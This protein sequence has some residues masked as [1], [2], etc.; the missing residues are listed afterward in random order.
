MAAP[1]Y[2]S[3]SSN[4]NYASL[5]GQTYAELG[6]DATDFGQ[7]LYDR[8]EPWWMGDEKRG[9][10]LRDYCYAIGEMFGEVEA[11]ARED[12]AGNPP[13][14]AV[15]DVD[16]IPAKNLPWLA[17]LAGVELIQGL[18][19]ADTRAFIKAAS[20]RARG[21]RDSIVAA[22]QVFLTG[23]K[24][25]DVIE[26]DG[27]P[28]RL[29]VVTHD[30]E[31]PDPLKVEKAIRTVKPAGIVLNYALANLTYS[32]LDT[33]YGTYAA[34]DTAFVSYGDMTRNDPL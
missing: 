6:A 31:T 34:Q 5:E 1:S 15:L 4:P 14:S 11:L 29:T 19:E 24:F 20:G 17:Q 28:Y 8:L 10:P 16:R 23:T 12:G 2:K 3:L 27:S 9:Y 32:A 7:R 26:R 25:V 13:W 30:D 21:T 22:A 18:S 33:A